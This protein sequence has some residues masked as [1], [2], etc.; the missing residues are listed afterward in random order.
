ME[1]RKFSFSWIVKSELMQKP[2]TEKK[3]IVSEL[4]VFMRV[5]GSLSLGSGIIFEVDK[6]SYAKRLYSHIKA[7]YGIS[8]KIHLKKFNRLGKT[9]K[10]FIRITEKQVCMSMLKDTMYINSA[11]EL[12]ISQ[13]IRKSGRKTTR[14]RQNI[15]RCAFLLCGS[16][17]SPEKNY[18]MEMVFADSTLAADIADTM[19]DSGLKAKMIERKNSTVV[20]LK[21]AEEIVDFLTFIGATGSTLDFYNIKIIKEMRNNVNRVVNCETANIG[22]TVNAA[23]RQLESIGLIDEK[24][25]LSSLPEDLYEAASLRL[26]NPDMSLNDMAA[27]CDPVI[28][29]SGL[30]HRFKRIDKIA[31]GLK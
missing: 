28:S 29:K 6:P 12:I 5:C 24:V 26:A 1:Q 13:G 21:G 31:R 20:Y 16:V 3:D 25:G 11:G 8:S 23:S 9:Y 4:I 15:L 19:E 7:V 18:H 30:N 14:D 22:K 17:S 2:L 10:Y 27:M